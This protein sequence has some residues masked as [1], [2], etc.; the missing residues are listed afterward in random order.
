MPLSPHLIP[1]RPLFY[2]AV[3]SLA[4]I[5]GLSGC[6]TTEQ[7]LKPA[8]ES[9]FIKVVPK[10]QPAPPP[11][12]L[13]KIQQARVEPKRIFPKLNTLL[14]LTA[15]D[16]H[17]LL[18]MP[19]FKRS[20]NPAEIWQYRA[21]S[22]ILDLFLY[23]NLDTSVRSVAHYEIRL[24]NSQGLTDKDCFESVIKLADASIKTS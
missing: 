23:E 22:C 5:T 6:T 17:A 16:V 13:P 18:G 11:I 10:A 9:R 3:L 19:S 8:P 14:N 15:K 2:P 20:D 21:A 12:N 24:Q 4:L 7:P 1:S